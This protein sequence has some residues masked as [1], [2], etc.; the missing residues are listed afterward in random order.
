MA[1]MWILLT[2][3]VMTPRPLINRIGAKGHSQIVHMV[4]VLDFFVSREHLIKGTNAESD[5]YF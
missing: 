1:S 2:S 5:S 4:G 3:L